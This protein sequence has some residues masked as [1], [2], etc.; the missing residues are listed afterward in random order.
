MQVTQNI[1]LVV[2][3]P[4][5]GLDKSIPVVDTVID[6]DY[7]C[8]TKTLMEKT[9]VYLL[10]N[11]SVLVLNCFFLLHPLCH[12]LLLTNPIMANIHGLAHDLELLLQTALGIVTFTQGPCGNLCV[13]TNHVPMAWWYNEINWEQL[14]KDKSI[15]LITYSE[16]IK[17]YFPEY[18]KPFAPYLCHLASATW[19]EGTPLM[20]SQASHKISLKRHSKLS[21]CL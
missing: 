19:S 4:L 17:E 10:L 7:P 16:E 11:C 5:T 6:Y 3:A 14:F 18:W 9:S 8:S 20:S 2:P 13:L 21:K 12:L 15:D 1:T